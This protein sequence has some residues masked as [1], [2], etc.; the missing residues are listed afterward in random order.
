[1]VGQFSNGEHPKLKMK[2]Q[3]K[4]LSLENELN[5]NFQIVISM[6]C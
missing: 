1:M 5:N 3:C 4:L 6:K 2:E